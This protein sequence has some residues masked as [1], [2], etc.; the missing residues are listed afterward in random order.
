MKIAGM[1]LGI[2]GG[3]IAI[4]YAAFLIF[5]G[6]MFGT[7]P[8]Q[9]GLINESQQ[10]GFRVFTSLGIAGLIGGVC[11]IVGG[12]LA[13]KKRV[14]SGVLMLVGS[15]LSMVGFFNFLSFILLVLGGIF[16]LIPDKQTAGQPMPVYVVQP[17]PQANSAPELSSEPRPKQDA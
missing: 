8:V 13:L 17:A 2:I 1:V 4:V 5:G 6:A 11:G 3:M 10:F 14:L 15:V 9:N 16:V 12:A 7:L